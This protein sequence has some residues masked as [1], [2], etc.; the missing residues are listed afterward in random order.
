MYSI[1]LKHSKSAQGNQIII[2]KSNTTF[3]PFSSMMKFLLYHFLTHLSAALFINDG[4]KPLRSW[5]FSKP[6]DL[7]PN[8]SLPKEC[9]FPHSLRTGTATAAF[10]LPT[11]TLKSPGCCLSSAYQLYVGF[12]K[13]EVLSVQKFMSSYTLLH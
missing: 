12:H 10:H 5:F 3:C 2:A 9:Y 4:C 7:C 13:K 8:C 1:L 11:S 6:C